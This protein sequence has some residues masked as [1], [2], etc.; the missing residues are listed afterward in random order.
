M[1]AINNKIKES[2]ALF[3][4][5]DHLVYTTYPIIKENK[6]LYSSIVYLDKA[7]MTAISAWVEHEIYYKRISPGP[8]DLN[9]KFHIF[10]DHLAR[11]HSIPLEYMKTIMEIKSV[12][13]AYKE[14]PMAFSRKDKFVIWDDDKLK[15]LELRNLKKY[16]TNSRLFI[17]LVENKINVRRK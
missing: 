14:S 9:S 6:L 1:E 10:K 7:L 17:N 5:A 12:I 13:R 2:K 3:V 11:K 16:L 15:T 8:K 4:R